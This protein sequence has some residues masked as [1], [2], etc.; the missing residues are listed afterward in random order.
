MIMGWLFQ[1]RN[2]G[3]S[4]AVGTTGLDVCPDALL[5][6]SPLAQPAGPFRCQ[7]RPERH[8]GWQIRTGS[9]SACR[10]RE[11]SST[12]P[13]TSRMRFVS[14]QLGEIAAELA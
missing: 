13:F 5:R 6:A 8:G 7:Y 1:Q 3:M 14:G 12:R 10:K 4:G 2:I 9:Y 11:S